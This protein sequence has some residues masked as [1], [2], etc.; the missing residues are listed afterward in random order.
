MKGGYEVTIEKLIAG[1]EGLGRIDGKIVFVPYVIPGERVLVEVTESRKDYCRGR[2]NSIVE[3]SPERRRPICP[4]FGSCGGC[5]IQ[6]MSYAKQLIEKEAMLQESL[7][8]T[9]GIEASGI[10]VDGSPETDYR[11]KVRLHRARNGRLGFMEFHSNRVVHVEKC[12]VCVDAINDVIASPP[13]ITAD[14]INLMAVDSGVVSGR[15]SESMVAESVFTVAG[16][17]LRCS[18]DAFFQSNQALLPEFISHVTEGLGGSRLLDLYCGV[19]LFGAFLIG[20]FDQVVS[21]DQ[22][23]RAVN[24]ARKNI[25]GKDHRF[26]SQSVENWVLKAEIN[27]DTVIV[28]P[29]RPGLSPPVRE[30]LRACG[31]QNLVYVSCN[32]VTL[33]RDLSDLCRDS[34]EGKGFRI[35]DIRLFDFFPQTGHMET[36]VRLARD[37]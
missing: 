24:L 11:T 6:H 13:R 33:A 27:F 2:V 3:S 26:I 17:P 7:A 20:G 1:G 15:G 19:G 10:A 30:Y 35:K 22:D 18:P 25:P 34:R 23:S 16:R 28:D 32:P 21:V 36:V 4:Y 9:G 37:L 14:E 31:A 8:R 29:A 12:P 5:Q